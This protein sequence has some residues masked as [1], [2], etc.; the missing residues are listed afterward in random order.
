[1]DGNRVLM[2]D[3][4]QAEALNNFFSSVFSREVDDGPKLQGKIH[5]KGGDFSTVEFKK[6]R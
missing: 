4:E 6:K 3:G 2:D 5:L 1:M